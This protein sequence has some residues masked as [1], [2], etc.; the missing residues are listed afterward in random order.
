MTCP[1]RGQRSFTVA[2]SASKYSSPGWNCDPA[3]KNGSSNFLPHRIGLM[4]CVGTFFRS[5]GTRSPTDRAFHHGSH[6][7]Q[8]ISQP[9][10]W[11]GHLVSTPLTSLLKWLP[12]IHNVCISSFEGTN[13]HAAE[14]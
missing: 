10:I 6:L 11:R 3:I 4:F 5:H 9:G 1:S 8:S 7:T 13:C 2:W 14:Q 12:Q